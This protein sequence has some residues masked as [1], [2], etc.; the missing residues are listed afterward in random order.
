[1]DEADKPRVD[2]S[3][4]A[5]LLF[6]IG[7]RISVPSSGSLDSLNARP[8]NRTD[9]LGRVV[10]FFCLCIHTMACKRKS[11]ERERQRARAFGK[12]TRMRYTCIRQFLQLNS[13]QA[14]ST[15]IK[16][17]IAQM[18]IKIALVIDNPLKLKQIN[19]V[20][21]KTAQSKARAA[22]VEFFSFFLGF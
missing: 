11:L 2:S 8:E 22:I 16:P 6:I 1:M 21:M 17:K 13:R 10:L 9:R 12:S 14:L 20:Q 3:L 19:S 15:R 7:K 4:S 18:V 5:V